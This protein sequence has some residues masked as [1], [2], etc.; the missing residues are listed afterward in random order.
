MLYIKKYFLTL[1]N[2][3]LVLT[4]LDYPRPSFLSLLVLCLQL[5]SLLLEQSSTCLPLNL[6]KVVYRQRCA[7]RFISKSS[8]HF[9]WYRKIHN[10][11]HRDC[12]PS[13]LN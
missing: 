7:I 2:S 11:I 9:G 10:I 3:A 6:H 12:L 8:L 5:R 1:C 4:S 13:F